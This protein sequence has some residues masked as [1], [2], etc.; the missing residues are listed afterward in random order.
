MLALWRLQTDTNTLKQNPKTET[1]AE[2]ENQTAIFDSQQVQLY[3]INKCTKKTE[4]KAE[5]IP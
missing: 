2:T 3:P 5:L 4:K 1:A